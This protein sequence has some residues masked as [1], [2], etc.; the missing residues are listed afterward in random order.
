MRSSTWSI[1]R[2]VRSWSELTA[3]LEDLEAE[4]DVVA[5]AAPEEPEHPT[6]IVGGMESD[7]HSGSDG[8]FGRGGSITVTYDP[9]AKPYLLAIRLSNSNGPKPVFMEAPVAPLW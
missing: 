4:A 2:E 8:S 1:L 6:A 3:V 5:E 7:G 9:Q